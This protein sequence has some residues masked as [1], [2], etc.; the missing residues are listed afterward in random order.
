ME[1]WLQ[2][3]LIAVGV[4]AAMRIL[5]YLVTRGTRSGIIRANTSNVL[6]VVVR[7]VGVFSIVL[8]IFIVFEIN[9]NTIQII[10]I[11]SFS[12]AFI[13]FAS[14]EVM[15]QIISGIYII[16]SR[17]F[18]VH[19]LV[20]I[21]DV[22]GI[23]MEIGLNYTVVQKLDG[24]TVKIPNKTILDSKIKDFT[25]KLDEEIKK[26]QAHLSR[27]DQ[28]NVR[29]VNPE[30]ARKGKIDWKKLRYILDDLTDFA[31]EEE[32]TRF[33]FRFDGDFSIPSNVLR[34]RLDA[35][36]K[37]YQPVFEHLPQYRLMN[38]DFRPE[39]QMI[40]YCFSPFVI[41]HNMDAFM[42]DIAHALYAP[43]E[44]VIQ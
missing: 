17:S 33:V 24:N 9:I 41:L 38:L 35:I 18:G 6:K 8:S 36:C 12:G 4:L 43:D 7:I 2:F 29:N 34:E 26:R 14:S 20:Q 28:V 37:Q 27:S 23:V 13:G 3:L 25:I 40:I 19:D 42:S 32:I 44:E 1:P 30:A 11:S 15:S 10:S 21:D 5:V 22:I 31:F 16:S 39:F